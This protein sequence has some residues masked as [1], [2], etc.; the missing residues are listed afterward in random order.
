MRS[1]G[2]IMQRLKVGKDGMQSAYLIEHK[3]R[4]TTML[5]V[6]HSC[7]TQH[8]S[9]PLFRIIIYIGFVYRFPPCLCKK[10]IC[11]NNANGEIFVKYLS[12]LFLS[13]LLLTVC[14]S[15]ASAS[16]IT[17][18][19][20]ESTCTQPGYILTRDAETDIT[21][22][23][24]LAAPGHAFG[25]YTP[26]EDRLTQTRIC[27]VCSFAET[28]RISTISDKDFPRLYLTGSMDG[29]GKKQ[30]IALEASFSGK[31]QS[32]ACYAIMTLQGHSTFGLPKHN[33]TV[34]F[35]DDDQALLKHKLR[36][37]DWSS[38][39]KYI[40]KAC[41]DDPSLCRNLVS[42]RIWR[43][44]TA[45]RSNLSPRIAMLPT[46]GTVDGF[47]VEVYLNNEYFGLYTLNLHK[48]DDLYGMK[49][50]EHAALI[51]CNHRTTNESLFR[52][53]AAFAPDYTSDWELEYCGT[54]NEEW[55]KRS[56]NALIDF[57]MHSSDDEFRRKLKNHLDVDAAIDYL[58]FMYALGLPQSCAKD[59][60]LLSYGDTWIPAAYDMDKAFGLDPDR[61]AYLSPD[62]FL[63]EKVN[64][65][66]RS[67]TDSLLWD[68]LLNSFET[69]IQTRYTRLRQ[70][71][72]SEENILNH[73]HTFIGSIPE[74]FY[75][76]DM[77]LYASRPLIA[78]DM[79]KQITDYVSLRFAAL[80]P[81]LM[82]EI[83]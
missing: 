7:P 47:P 62:D 6:S 20:V 68:R 18:T 51:I 61:A 74:S 40:L 33:Y 10:Q 43:E 37:N 82:E 49:N 21:Q 46:L 29:I 14:P 3:P 55:A 48:D 71:V 17:Q 2:A 70:S 8:L 39:H 12:Y 13:F 9:N 73:I 58:I 65:L 80:D 34:R 1:A 35:Y 32:F 56:F 41:Y 27:S 30:K 24:H 63:P 19:I 11:F 67:G 66:W 78:A 50:G 76:M 36:F 53:P 75:D 79:E 23:E 54:P 57:V 26:D 69:D 38:E 4:H 28:I 42:A 31:G 25:R 59:M 52:S 15:G 60:V 72:L 44:M 45:C 81:I 16:S 64:G 22:I 83:P 5:R 77:N